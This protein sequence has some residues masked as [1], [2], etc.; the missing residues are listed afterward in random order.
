MGGCLLVIDMQNGFIGPET[1]SVVPRVKE[2]LERWE[3]P[4]VATQFVNGEGS[5]YTEIMGWRGMMSSPDTDLL[6]FVRERADLVI[7]KHLYTAVCPE[8]TEFLRKN[9]VSE[10]SMA[11]VDT[12]CCVLKNA[13]DLFESGIRPRVLLYY[14]ASNGG[15]ESFRAAERVLS[16]SIGESCLCRGKI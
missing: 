8:L 14:T 11:G 10:V 15:E 16:R 13:E 12:D 3:G 7:E 4:V 2:L 9:G 5:P 6:D 1:Q